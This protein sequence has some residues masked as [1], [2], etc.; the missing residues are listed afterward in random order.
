MPKLIL[1]VFENF[2]IIFLVLLTLLAISGLGFFE[3]LRFAFVAGLV[4]VSG[5]QLWKMISTNY[6]LS[7]FEFLGMGLAFGSTI[8]S[9]LQII[10]RATPLGDIAWLFVGIFIPMGIKLELNQSIQ[11]LNPS[12]APSKFS[13]IMQIFFDLVAV[14]AFALAWYWWWIYP[15]AVVITVVSLTLRLH[16]RKRT[17]ETLKF[18]VLSLMILA[19][20]YIWCTLLRSRNDSWKVISHDQVFSES[21]SWSLNSFGRGD[22][23]FLSGFEINYHWLTLHWAGLLTKA[24]NGGPWISVTR[25]IPILSCLGIFCLLAT[26]SSKIGKGSFSV[27]F[28]AIPFLFLSNTFGFN[29][30]RYIV[31]PTFQFTC[32]WMLATINILFSLVEDFSWT[33]LS[34]TGFM[35]FATLGGKLMNG[36]VVL[37]GLTMVVLIFPR[38]SEVK[39]RRTLNLALLVSTL[40]TVCAYLYFFQSD[41]AMEVNSL[42]FA[43]QIGSDVGI[44]RPE[45]RTAVQILGALIFILAMSMPVVISVIFTQKIRKQEHLKF[46]LLSTSM[47]VGILA[48]TLTTHEGASQL[49]FMLSAFVVSL[50]VYPVIARIITIASSA[51]WKI[52]FFSATFGVGSQ[53]IWN[54]SNHLSKYHNS[55]FFKLIAVSIC[56]ILA[57]SI[58]LRQKLNTSDAN[59][60]GES[61]AQ[62]FFL[63]VLVSSISIGLF[64]RA[65]RLPSAS[66]S[67]PV[68]QEDQTLITGS[69]DHLEVLNWVRTRTNTDDIIA[70]NRFCIPGVDSCIMKW[71]L[72]SAISHRRVLIEG[73]Y[74]SPGSLQAGE[75]QDRFDISSRFANSPDAVSLTHLCDRGVSWFFYDSYGIPPRVDWQPYATVRVSNKS[76]SLLELNCSLNQ[77]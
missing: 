53:L 61:F 8:A 55:I 12:S 2:S 29:L 4:C 25:V 35:M 27:A 43:L 46:D 18:Y 66:R 44:V 3:S 75:I 11:N 13:S 64:Q 16:I 30:E 39:D 49:Y 22:S 14:I 10:L 33:K 20:V 37:G 59:S 9:F 50:V 76:V 15:F 72:V 19:P 23:P 45:S 34:F 41:Q 77:M 26:L 42:K 40:S 65:E 74:G 47:T 68:N 31:S 6:N 5:G 1:R 67:V 73:G 60:L 32:I 48:T 17:K 28:T 7:S 54:Y 57:L 71:Q 70:I 63:V 51:Y 24:S 21:L 62:I 58:Y 38:P 52:L 36:L 69:S 56:P